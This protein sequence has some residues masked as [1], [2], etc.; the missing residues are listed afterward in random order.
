MR[1]VLGILALAVVLN[2]VSWLGFT[3]TQGGDALNG[4]IE[5]GRYYLGSHGHYTEV[6]VG[7]YQ[8]SR[9]QTV[10]NMI[11][12]PIVIGGSLLWEYRRRGKLRV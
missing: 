5:D 4:K 8:F 11:I 6:S 2:L 7:K 1:I 3:V 12:L 9:C 10:S